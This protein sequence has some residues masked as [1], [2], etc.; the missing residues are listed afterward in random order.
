MNL[1]T[2]PEELAVHTEWYTRDPLTV[3]AAAQP[4][5][6]YLVDARR[7]RYV[8]PGFAVVVL[9][10]V[11]TFF[12]PAAA[13]W[14]AG[15]SVAIMVALAIAT[16]GGDGGMYEVTPQGD[17]L[18]LEDPRINQAALRRVRRRLL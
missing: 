6:V 3:T 2:L 18:K 8:L 12:F 1:T 10:I 9:L 13:L 16:R 15:A 14:F 4:E 5:Y 17:L 7:R 11:A